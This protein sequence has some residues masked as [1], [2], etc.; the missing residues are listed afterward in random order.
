M[1]FCYISIFRAARQ[2]SLRL[3]RMSLSSIDS[4]ILL[5]SQNQIALTIFILLIVFIICW[6]PFFS[7]MMY[8]ST[9]H[10]K[11]PDEFAQSLG[12]V[13]YWFLFL[14]SSIN[15]FAYGV[16]NPL[17]RKELY[18][19]CC[20]R[21]QNGQ[22]RSSS[23]KLRGSDHDFYPGPPQPFASCN[24]SPVYPAYINVDT[25]SEEEIVSPNEGT[26]K[27]TTDR[28]TQTGQVCHILSVQNLPRVYF[29]NKPSSFIRN[30]TPLSEFKSLST[31]SAN[32][33]TC[34]TCPSTCSESDHVM[35]SGSEEV[36]CSSESEVNCLCD[37]C[38]SSS[39]CS[40]NGPC[41][42]QGDEKESNSCSLLSRHTNGSD[43]RIKNTNKATLVS[44]TLKSRERF[45]VGWIESQL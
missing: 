26:G 16:R 45:K 33:V 41:C 29:T 34:F 17:I 8:M 23:D 25:L 24:I 27:L 42:C 14:N 7:Y 4:E 39:E 5:Y 43:Y 38:A 35:I 10:I 22:R 44:T 11:Y 30:E 36:T 21:S 40:T 37:E 32:E 31:D 28:E 6:T 15:P 1:G 18:A 9:N 20:R 19:K 3:S 2:H 12:L 13:S